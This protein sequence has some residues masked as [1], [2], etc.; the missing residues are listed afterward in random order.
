MNT[1]PT[2]LLLLVFLMVF[3][4]IIMIRSARRF[5]RR[6]WGDGICPRGGCRH[7]N[8]PDAKFCARCGTSLRGE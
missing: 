2:V 3:S 5:N 1:I 4:G 8:R 7:R 6:V